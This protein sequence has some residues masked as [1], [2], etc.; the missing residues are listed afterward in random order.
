MGAIRA[1]RHGVLSGTPSSLWPRLGRGCLGVTQSTSW[2]SPPTH[3]HQT[4][5]IHTNPEELE[6]GTVRNTDRQSRTTH[7]RPAAVQRQ[8]QPPVPPGC[9]GHDHSRQCDRDHTT[10]CSSAGGPD[11][12]QR[13]AWLAVEQ[14]PGLQ[15]R[16]DAS[17]TTLCSGICLQSGCATKLHAHL[18]KATCIHRHTHS[19]TDRQAHPRSFR[20]APQTTQWGYT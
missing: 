15:R 9:H 7:M 5:P 12:H 3:P 17:G 13:G 10:G 4:L 18:P 16:A 11:S 8:Q 2:R 19:L 1:L 14:L 6:G 20:L